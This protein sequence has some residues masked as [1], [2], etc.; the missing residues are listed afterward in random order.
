MEEKK[1]G[2]RRRGLEFG[3]RM[4]FLFRKMEKTDAPLWVKDLGK[5]EEKK[6]RKKNFF[7][8]GL[9]PG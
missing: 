6:E 2:K 7:L 9:K 3:G 8:E 4:K 1:V 5:S